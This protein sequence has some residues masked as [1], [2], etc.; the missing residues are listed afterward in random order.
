MVNLL[1]HGSLNQKLKYLKPGN[2]GYKKDF[3]YAVSCKA[4]A[5]IFINR[6]GGSLVASWGRLK[7]GLPYFCERKKGIFKSNY[8]NQKGSIYVVD[9]KYFKQNKKLWEE[10]WVSEQKVPIIEEIK[11][12]N[13]KKYLL[14]LES[15][16]KIKIILFKD[17]KK[18]F[19]NIDKELIEDAIKLIEKYGYEKTLPS[20]KKNQPKI[21]DKVK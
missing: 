7:N 20:I 17:R 1:Y 12:K 5:A 14:E 6:K 16:G 15:K 21:L 9:K 8:N 4:F 13:L 3:V 19:P 18:F 11:I 10:E 2:G